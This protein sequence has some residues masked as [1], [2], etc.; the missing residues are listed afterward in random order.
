MRPNVVAAA[1]L[2]ILAAALTTAAEQTPPAAGAG[3]ATPAA[4][5]IRAMLDRLH[6]NGEFTGSILVA[7]AGTIVYRDAI[8]DTPAQATA[9]LEQPVDIGSLAKGFTAMAVMRLHEQ[10]KLAYDDPASRYVPG[11]AATPAITIRHL[12]AHTS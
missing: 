9:E 12:L 8:A 2:L 4:A 11:L 10:G 3:A 6:A 1:P 7:R 5:T